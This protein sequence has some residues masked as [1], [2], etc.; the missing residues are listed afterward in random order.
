MEGM[1][2]PKTSNLDQLGVAG[3][4]AHLTMVPL[5]GPAQ[6]V[7]KPPTSVSLFDQGLSQVLQAAATGLEPRHSYV[8][9][10]ASRPDGSGSLEP[11]ASFM[12]NPTGA[13][14][15]NALGPIRQVVRDDR[16]DSRRYLVIAPGTM[17][18]IGKPVQVQAP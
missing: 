6:A 3:E 2:D 17:T 10:F 15:V 13:A 16:Q 9:A 14:I 5:G 8:L 1:V 18:E 11:I 12:T 7:D 4:V